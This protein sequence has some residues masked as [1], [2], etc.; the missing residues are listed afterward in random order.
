MSQTFKTPKGTTLPMLDLRGK[1][2]LQVAHRIVWFREEHENWSI[3]TEQ[4]T[5]DE[6][7]ALF[8]ARIKDETGRVIA[9]A[10]G[11]ETKNDF[12][13]FIEK[14]ETKAV[15]RALAYCGY[16]TQFAPELDE[17]QR[18][19]DAPTTPAKPAAK[20]PVGERQFVATKPATKTELM[21][22]VR[23]AE[24]KL[25]AKAG[26]GVDMLDKLNKKFSFGLMSSSDINHLKAD[27]IIKALGA[28]PDVD[29]LDN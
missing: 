17:G 12:P 20:P 22:I 15:G 3:E 11:S 6:S 28:M 14:A 23:L 19:A 5:I 26:D 10:T 2:Y 7:R 16:G 27:T 9:N 24:V 18:L 13:D 21:E 1:P 25:G 29:P 8:T 4:L